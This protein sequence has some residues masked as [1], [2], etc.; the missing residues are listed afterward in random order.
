MYNAVLTAQQGKL[1][2]KAI[3]WAISLTKWDYEGSSSWW[4]L[5]QCYLGKGDTVMARKTVDDGLARHPGD[6]LLRYKKVDVELAC[7]N[8][9]AA[10]AVL[11]E[12]LGGG[13]WMD[14]YTNGKV[15]NAYDQLANPTGSDG[16]ALPKPF[17]YELLWSR[18]EFFYK[19]ALEQKPDYFDIQYDLGILYYNRAAYISEIDPDRPEGSENA[20]LWDEMLQ[21]ASVELE[22]ARKLKPDDYYTLKGLSVCYAYMGESEKYREVKDK[23]K[24]LDEK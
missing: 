13:S 18:A 7:G 16:T 14:P 6:I 20:M 15:G 21:K 24:G 10:D 2:D 22:K 9:A 17:N 19:K 4:M 11:L 3:P 12:M 5:A 8:N 23:L 1:Y